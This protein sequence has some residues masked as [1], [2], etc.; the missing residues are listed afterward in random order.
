MML[1]NWTM[2]LERIAWL[3]K[4]FD[5][6]QLL[7][8]TPFQSPDLAP[9]LHIFLLYET[10]NLNIRRENLLLWAPQLVTTRDLAPSQRPSFV[11][12]PLSLF[13]LLFFLCAYS[14]VN[15]HLKGSTLALV[16]G[17]ILTIAAPISYPFITLLNLLKMTLML[18]IH[19]G[20]AW[21]MYLTVIRPFNVMLVSIG[22]T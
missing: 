22:I 19:V 18:G 2:I 17:K 9:S 21:E 7:F 5:P 14:W 13:F 1:E 4:F 11:F 8:G 10:P 15:R 6:S 12:C 20:P 16:I 3:M